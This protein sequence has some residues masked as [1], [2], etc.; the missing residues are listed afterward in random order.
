MSCFSRDKQLPIELLYSN[1]EN[2]TIQ[3]GI[4]PT[5]LHISLTAYDISER[6]SLLVLEVVDGAEGGA[7]SASRPDGVP[8]TFRPRA[9]GFSYLLEPHAHVVTRHHAKR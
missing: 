2:K 3:I 6:N 7:P 8:P 4:F 9:S 1:R 5:A